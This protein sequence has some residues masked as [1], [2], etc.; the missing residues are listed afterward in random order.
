MT[1]ICLRSAKPNDVMSI[2]EWRNDPLSR[3]MSVDIAEVDFKT[4]EKWFVD[5][6]ARDNC[7]LFI[8][9]T[10]LDAVSVGVVRFDSDA[11]IKRATVSINLSPQFRGMGMGYKC[12]RQAI[13]MYREQDSDCKLIVA[14][15]KSN[16]LASIKSFERAGFN[17]MQRSTEQN[18]EDFE[19]ED[20]SSSDE[21]LQYELRLES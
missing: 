2:F 13:T 20:A 8:A 1:D 9:Q 21:L 17:L 7:Q 4:H 18:S 5:A 6:L 14:Q 19:K 16:N 11:N 3:S 15:I 12:L 10:R